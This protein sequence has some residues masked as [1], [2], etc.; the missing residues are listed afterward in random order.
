MAQQC[1]S[2]IHQTFVLQHVIGKHRRRKS[3]LYLWFVELKS[4]YDRVQWQLLGDLLRRLG[5]QGTMLGAIQ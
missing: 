5:V 2:T 4:A 1:D 3:P